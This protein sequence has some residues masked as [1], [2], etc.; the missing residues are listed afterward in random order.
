MKF[1]TLSSLAFFATSQAFAA[2]LQT[3]QAI[4]SGFPIFRD[5]FVK[6][7]DVQGPLAN[8]TPVVLYVLLG[9]IFQ[10]YAS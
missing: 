2:T 6:C 10:E 7:I 8:G 5:S 1:A 3:R 4:P 9:I